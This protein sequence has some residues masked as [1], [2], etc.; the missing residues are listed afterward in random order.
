MSKPNK[1]RRKLNRMNRIRQ[2][3]TEITAGPMDE[4]RPLAGY[5]AFYEITRNGDIYS[6]RLKRFIKHKFYSMGDLNSTYLEFT[7]SGVQVKLGVGQA[8]ASTYLSH[9]DTQDIIA[10]LPAEIRTMEALKGCSITDEL[11]KAYKITGRAIFTVLKDEVA[12]RL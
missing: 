2:S 12:R 7:V 9:Q 6:K 4:R 11:A 8:V 5:E 10:R 1:H 3:A